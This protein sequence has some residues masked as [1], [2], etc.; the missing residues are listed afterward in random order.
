VLVEKAMGSIESVLAMALA[1]E[2]GNF[3]ED[4]DLGVVLGADAMLRLAPGLV[5]MPDVSYVAW[6]R[7]PGGRFPDKPISDLAPDLAVEVLSA[8][9]TKREMDRKVQEYFEAHV[10]LVWLIDPRART[11]DVYTGPTGPRR[12]RNGQTLD[13]A[14]VLPGFELPLRRLFARATRRKKR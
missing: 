1:R 13:G 11:V 9:N 10:R 4:D 5:R 6:D 12:L 14:P 7:I 8:G 2:I 3:I